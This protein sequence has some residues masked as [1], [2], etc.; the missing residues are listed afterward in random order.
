[1]TLVEAARLGITRVRKQHWAF[2][3]DVLELVVANGHYGPWAVLHSP[4]TAAALHDPSRAAQTVFVLG[5]NA[6]D[7]V[8]YKP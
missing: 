4:D 5:D 3:D 6:A 7:W 8:E 1:M 2:A